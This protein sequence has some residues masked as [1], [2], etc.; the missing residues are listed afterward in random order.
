MVVFYGGNAPAGSFT[1]K[2]SIKTTGLALPL[3]HFGE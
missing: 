1:L 3:R 2:I